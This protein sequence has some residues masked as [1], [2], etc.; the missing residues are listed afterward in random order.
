MMSRRSPRQALATLL[1]GALL[2]TSAPAFAQTDEQRAA[3]REL[4]TEGAKAFQEGKYDQSLD[5]FTKAESLYHALPHLLFIARANAKLGRYVKAREAYLKVTKEVLPANAPAAARSAQ[6]SAASE[7][8][9]VESK[10]GRLTVTVEGKEQARDLVVSVDGAPMSAVLVGVPQP[11]D[12]G[13]HKIDA[14]A[15]GF[16]APQQIVTIPPGGRV[17]VVLTLAPDATAVAPV[18]GP[19]A[20]APVAAE[21]A[22]PPPAEPPP[23]SASPTADGGDDGAKGLRIGSYVG[24][25]VGAVGLGLGT[26][27]LIQSAGSRSDADALC[28]L[29]GGA[30]PLDVKPQV[31]ELDGD[32][33]TQ[34]A[35]GVTGLIVGGLGVA[36]GVTLLV[37]AGQKS[38]KSASVLPYIGPNSAGVT[39]TF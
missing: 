24:F 33:D 15:T 9:D 14:V 19:A 6:E 27:F 32:A 18:V 39:G 8:G 20:A 37:L 26:V 1:I 23:S 13:D 4:A 3:A 12:P 17:P 30:C 34:A 2:A 16:R 11:I 29:P 25:G 22:T 36:A 5:L 7:M 21:P 31:D 10:I 28:T 38:K 35:I